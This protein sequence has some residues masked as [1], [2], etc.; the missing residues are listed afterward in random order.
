M[1]FRV[2]ITVVVVLVSYTCAEVQRPEIAGRHEGDQA[3]TQLCIE[4]LNLI[5]EGKIGIELHFLGGF[6][7]GGSVGKVFNLTNGQKLTLFIPFWYQDFPDDIRV[8]LD[9]KDDFGNQKQSLTLEESPKLKKALVAM[10][11]ELVNQKVRLKSLNKETLNE[12]QNV[13]KLLK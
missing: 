9:V 12:L 3:M 7:D 11:S 4:K 2:W 6:G 13:R 5:R 1:N 8:W 10:V